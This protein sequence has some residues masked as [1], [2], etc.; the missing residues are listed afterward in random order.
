MVK[1]LCAV[2]CGGI[3]CAEKEKPGSRTELRMVHS[4][5][6]VLTFKGVLNTV[7]SPGLTKVSGEAQWSRESSTIVSTVQ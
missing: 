3:G 7:K 1:V 4:V 6:A 2:C 5:R